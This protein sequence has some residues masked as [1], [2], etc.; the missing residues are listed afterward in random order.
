M[1]TKPTYHLCWSC[2]R[3]FRGAH[4]TTVE[5]EN[6]VVFVHKQCAEQLNKDSK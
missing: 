5:T 6:G 1:T 2:N 3:K 4:F